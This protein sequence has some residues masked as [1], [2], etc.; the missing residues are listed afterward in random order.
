MIVRRIFA[1]VSAFLFLGAY[2]QQV[3]AADS[4]D[5]KEV[6]VVSS[7]DSTALR[8][9]LTVPAQGVK[10][11]LLFQSGSGIQDR[12]EEILG[13]RPFKAL[14]EYLSSEGYAVLRLDDRGYGNEID[15]T[16]EL[17]FI[18]SDFVAD[19]TS[20]LSYLRENVAG[21]PIGVL[22]H[23]EGGTTAMKLAAD[24]LCDFLVTLAAPAWPGDSMIMAQCRVAAVMT[25]GSWPG[26]TLQRQ[27]LDVAKGNLPK[28]QKEL[29]LYSLI[30][31]AAGES[32]SLPQVQQAIKQQI[33]ILV[34]PWYV[35]MLRYD[36]R[37]TISR[38]NV[39]W[40]ALNGDTDRQV[41]F[42]NLATISEFNPKAEPV[43]MKNHNH[44]FLET[45]N[46]L[47]YEYASLVGDISDQTLTTILNWLEK[48]I[49]NR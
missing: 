21:V 19:A 34:S 40:L 25:M 45:S 12:D 1:F 36:P 9:T 5:S 43:V 32:A 46:G 13:H 17:T 30:S 18:N 2:C 31:T 11:A 4:F 28:M 7:L 49:P 48:T 44:L 15:A 29:V 35:D 8:G 27:I 38:I 14:A 24:S 23:S 10:A 22:G 42:G 6:V 37:E 20:A 3:N 16:D 47:P 26:E 39:P 41:L 33:E